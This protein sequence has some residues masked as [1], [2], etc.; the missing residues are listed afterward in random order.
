MGAPKMHQLLLVCLGSSSTYGG[1]SSNGSLGEGGDQRRKWPS[2]LLPPFFTGNHC[3]S[4]FNFS[5]NKCGLCFSQPFLRQCL[6][7]TRYKRGEGNVSK[8]P[9]F[10]PLLSTRRKKKIWRI[11]FLLSLSPHPRAVSFPPDARFHKIVQQESFF[12]AGKS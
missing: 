3:K 8:A 1:F 9:C 5:L 2:Y 6:G 11:F 7:H 4:V 12:L 10:F